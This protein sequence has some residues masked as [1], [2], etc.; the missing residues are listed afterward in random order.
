MIEMILMIPTAGRNAAI[1]CPW[2][3]QLSVIFDIAQ[4]GAMVIPTGCKIARIVKNTIL[5]HHRA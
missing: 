3:Y 1:Q 4:E 2:S 5:V